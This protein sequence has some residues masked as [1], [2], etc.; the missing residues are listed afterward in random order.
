MYLG[1]LSLLLLAISGSVYGQFDTGATTAECDSLQPDGSTPTA[2]TPPFIVAVTSSSYTPG[3]SAVQVFIASASNVVATGLVLQARRS[4]GNADNTAFGS[5]NV[6]SGGNYRSL[7]CGTSATDTITNTNTN[8]KNLPLSFMWTPPAENVGSIEFIVSLVDSNG[9]FWSNVPSTAAV[10][11]T[12]GEL[13]PLSIDTC[14]VPFVNDNNIGTWTAPNCFRDTEVQANSATCVQPSGTPFPVGTSTVVCTCSDRG[15]TAQCEI[16][17]DIVVDD[18]CV[19]NPC[20]NGGTCIPVSSIPSG[21]FCQCPSGFLQPTCTAGTPPSAPN[22][23]S[24]DVVVTAPLG[25]TAV[26]V[27]YDT[28]ECTDAEDGTLTASCD[29]PSMTFFTLGT[30]IVTCTCADSTA[31]ISSCTFNVIVNQLGG[32]CANNPCL[33]NECR[34]SPSSL[35]GYT[36]HSVT[37]TPC[38]L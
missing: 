12:Q 6:P 33:G 20:D 29:S 16:T 31:Q 32:A 24:S 38:L 30:T 37:G 14:P 15:E 2:G 1:L 23:P 36:C 8:S 17:I 35:A 27:N 18:P 28:I 26:Q 34:E 19:P 21:F 7:E 4:S 5:F 3:G 11:S 22:C 25:A 9:Q 13:N 10:P